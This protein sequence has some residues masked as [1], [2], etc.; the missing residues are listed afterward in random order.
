MKSVKDIKTPEDLDEFV[1]YRGQKYGIYDQYVA[2]LETCRDLVAVQY[3][4]KKFDW[5]T[6]TIRPQVFLIE[7]VFRYGMVHAYVFP[8]GFKTGLFVLLGQG[9]DDRYLVAL[10]FIEQS[11]TFV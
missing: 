1:K 8:D 10:T 9:A 11:N 2:M 5:P 6:A 4:G 7:G 3:P